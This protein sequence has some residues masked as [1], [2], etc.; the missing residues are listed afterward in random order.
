MIKWRPFWRIFHR[1]KICYW[2]QRHTPSHQIS[3]LMSLQPQNRTHFVLNRSFVG[4][5][6]FFLFFRNGLSILLVVHEKNSHRRSE[7]CWNS[8]GL[9]VKKNYF[10]LL[11][12]LFFIFWKGQMEKNYDI[13]SNFPNNYCRFIND[14]YFGY[15]I[16]L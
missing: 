2:C 15:K 5:W 4:T 11:D 16:F 14:Y 3:I 7:K 8:L 13:F 6:T 9:S 1:K 10:R 12:H